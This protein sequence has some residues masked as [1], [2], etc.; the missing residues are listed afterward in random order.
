[1]F[2]LFSRF[3]ASRTRTRRSIVSPTSIARRTRFAED[4]MEHGFHFHICLSLLPAAAFTRARSRSAA[5]N[6]QPGRRA[7]RA[8]RAA[9]K[10]GSYS[11][12]LS[13][14]ATRCTKYT[15][16]FPSFFFFFFF[17]P[18]ARL[19]DGGFTRAHAGADPEAFMQSI[20]WTKGPPPPPVAVA[21]VPAF[22]YS[23]ASSRLLSGGRQPQQDDV[24]RR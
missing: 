8:T 10:V 6:Q 14:L 5:A 15:S 23:A 4:G 16:F 19:A 22:D 17:L 11:I 13:S 24:L 18:L 20:G 21:A 3:Q 2:S 7:R 12:N 9:R 1:M